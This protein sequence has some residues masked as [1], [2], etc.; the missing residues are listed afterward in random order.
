MTWW[1][2]LKQFTNL[3][4]AERL[5]D[6]DERPEVK[7]LELDDTFESLLHELD[8]HLGQYATVK[9]PMNCKLIP[10]H[11]VGEEPIKYA[12]DQLKQITSMI[13]RMGTSGGN[14]TINGLDLELSREIDNINYSFN[15]R[16]HLLL[17]NQYDCI[18]LNTNLNRM[19]P[20][21]CL[22]PPEGASE[23]LGNWIIPAISSLEQ[24]MQVIPGFQFFLEDVELWRKWGTNGENLDDGMLTENM[25]DYDELWQHRF[26]RREKE[27]EGIPMNQ[28]KDR[29]GQFY[30][31][32]DDIFKFHST[33]WTPVERGREYDT[34]ATKMVTP[35]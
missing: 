16:I 11:G 18:Y 22:K 2:L 34:R 20:R 30:F 25:P 27:G 15:E 1:T 12:I 23:S 9:Q 4:Y 10:I 17:Q 19:L 13:H 21:I 26:S 7:A 28:L 29:V 14:L 6:I 32:S 24:Y 35:R 3:V 33:Y 31:S 8:G 5:L